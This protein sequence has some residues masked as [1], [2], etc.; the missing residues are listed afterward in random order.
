MP[1]VSNKIDWENTE[2]SFYKFVC[3][4]PEIKSTY[5]GHTTNFASRKYEHKGSC[6][7]LNRKNHNIP[8]YVFM[9]ENGGFE[10]WSMVQIHSQICKDS[11]EARQI[12]Q[13]LIEQQQLKLNVVKAFISEEQR[14]EYEVEYRL[15][16]KEEIAKYKVEYQQKNKEQIS[17]NHS[18]YYQQNKEQINKRVAD[19]TAHNREQISEYQASYREKNKEKLNKYKREYRKNK[20]AEK[21]AQSINQV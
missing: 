10:N 16:H 6:N 19:Y 20:K 21:E 5:V 4:N 17:I 18:A 11:L 8:L 12:E 2:V 15:Q 13:E 3:N 9:R 14:L 1:K 7:N